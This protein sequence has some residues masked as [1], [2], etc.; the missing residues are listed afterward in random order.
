MD[1]L[2]SAK[3]NDGNEQNQRNAIAISDLQIKSAELQRGHAEL[4]QKIREQVY[5]AV[6][7][8]DDAAR[9]FQI[10]QEVAKRNAARMQLLECR[11][12]LR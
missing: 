2:L 5:L 4:V 3:R 10:A 8:Y 7:D 12:S 6:F 11:I 9:E 1:F